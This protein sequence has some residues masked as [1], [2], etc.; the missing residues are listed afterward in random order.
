[1]LSGKIKDHRRDPSIRSSNLLSPTCFFIDMDHYDDIILYTPDGRHVRYFQNS[2]TFSKDEQFI[3]SQ[4]KREGVKKIL[5]LLIEK[6]GMNNVELSRNMGIQESAT[7]RYMKNL[8]EQSLIKKKPTSD[9]TSG[10]F[11]NDMYKQTI[12]GMIDRMNR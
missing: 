8:Q 10:F 7:S 2:N 9:G 11:I 4:L 5:M 1:V 3:V 6:P 12:I